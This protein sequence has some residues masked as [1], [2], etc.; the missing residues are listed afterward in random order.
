MDEEIVNIQVAV[1]NG[2]VE[3]LKQL[4]ATRS[5]VKNELFQAYAELKHR[6]IPL[7]NKMVH[8]VEYE[9]VK[10]SYQ[11]AYQDNDSATSAKGA[12]GE[13]AER[14]ALMVECIDLILN[15]HKPG[16]Y[17]DI[18]E[19][20][21]LRLRQIYAH[22]FF[23]KTHLRKLPLLQLQ[24][25]LAVFL[26]LVT[27]KP[28]NGFDIYAFTIDKER[29]IHFL[30]LTRNELVAESKPPLSLECYVQYVLFLLNPHYGT[31]RIPKRIRSY[32]RIGV[33]KMSADLVADIQPGVYFEAFPVP[34]QQTLKTHYEKTLDW[35]HRR[36]LR[37]T[38]KE[39][40]DTYFIMKQ[41]YSIRKVLSY[42]DGIREGPCNDPPHM[43]PPVPS[44]TRIRAIK[45]T[46]QV[47]GEMIKSTRE[48]PNITAKLNRILQLI[49]S[50]AL[51]ERTKDLRQFFSHGYSLAKWEM[52]EDA[53]SEQLA[54]VFQN[55]ETNLREVRRWFVYTQTQQNLLIYRRYLAHLK[56]FTSVV[57]LRSYISFVGTEFKASLI[58]TYLPEQL[59]EAK[60]LI[61]YMLN[62]ASPRESL[63]ADVRQDLEYILAEL[64]LRIDVIRVE[65][66]TL[67]RTIDEFFFLESYIRQPTSEL[68][69]VRQIVDWI[70]S[71]T[72]LSNRHKL[73]QKTDLLYARELLARLQMEETDDTRRYLWGN[74]WTR[75][76][77]ERLSGLDTL[78]GRTEQRFDVSLDATVRTMQALNLPLDGDEYV[79]FVN[80]RLA[81]SYYTNVFGLDNKY[82]VLKEI[83]KDRR[84]QVNSRDVLE[85]LKELRKTDERALQ[86]MFDGL[87]DSMEDI[88]NECD[89]TGDFRFSCQSDH[90]ALE[91]C[92]L[93]A[94]EILCNLALFR[95]NMV[96]LAMFVPV[97]TGRNLRNY[98]AHDFLAYDTLTGRDGGETVILNARYL[99]ENR[100]KLYNTASGRGPAAS[101][102]RSSVQRE[103]FRE[104][105]QRQ[106]E[107][108]MEQIDF[109][110]TIGNLRADSLEQRIQEL[111]GA[112]GDARL[113]LARRNT[114]DAEIVSIALDGNTSRFIAQLLEYE[115]NNSNFFHLL[116]K[117]SQDATL[118]E[119]LKT[120]IANPVDFCCHLALKYGLLDV[121]CSLY[122]RYNNAALRTMLGAEISSIFVRYS[123]EFI[124][125]L[126]E[127]FPSEWFQDLQDHI[128][129]TILHLMVLR[130]DPEMLL[131]ALRRY[132][133][134]LKAKNEIGD[135]PLLIACRYHQDA[136]VEMLLDHRA[137]A[138][139]EP[140]VVQTL[141]MRSSTALLERLPVDIGRIVAGQEDTLRTNPLRAAIEENQYDTFVTLH[142]VFRYR[143]HKGELLHLAARMNR[144]SFLRYILTTGQENPEEE[145]SVDSISKE[146]FFTPL[147]LACATGHYEA[148]ELL[149]RY[150]ADG[151]L[152]NVNHYTPW[153]CAVH[154]G[155][156]RI[157]SLLL[158]IQGLDVNAISRDKR[159]AL[160]IAI[161]TDQPPAK[162][163]FLLSTARVTVQPEHV[164]HACLFGKM[165][166]L[167]ML[168]ER[169]PQYLS[170]HDFLLRSPL[171]LAVVLNDNAM[172]QYLL[173]RGANR[174]TVNVLG[175]NCLHVA[176]LSNLITIC[177]TLLDAQMNYEAVDNFHRTPLVV[178]LENEHLTIADLLLQRGA[179]LKS[180]HDFRFKHHRN[181]TLLHKFTIEQRPRMVE[182]LVKKLHFPTD[183]LDDDGKT[184]EMYMGK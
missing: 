41:H 100:P 79:Q 44:P 101:K 141:A 96:D 35:D 91:Y 152:R 14:L 154:S 183:L 32:I 27:G 174:D 159:S 55:I 108:T 75:L 2:N 175:M 23:V 173:E 166:I 19:L 63:G 85:K 177:K 25:C 93:E 54:M 160:S 171:M 115:E 18:D 94:T 13:V 184:A 145:I 110:D 28:T 20:L 129:N 113:L 11:N 10:V 124:S 62:T 118:I 106:T 90:L 144:V 7:S 81:K 77:K 88:L 143:L 68:G 87:L 5:C 182:Y 158:S 42:I 40:I 78:L 15:E 111:E 61:Q 172:A 46:L 72:E 170:A 67:G 122:E 53:N 162:I 37:K 135:V 98:L 52:E 163:N 155:N 83:V 116:I 139:I 38:F 43:H 134:L 59:T 103:H 157:I 109:F 142:R 22:V 179:S 24:F 146:Y 99:V 151:L 4:L 45:R 138:W 51:T 71:R 132:Q 114:L 58:E 136:I 92:L 112:G 84:A 120:I 39:L 123:T 130:G 21:V 117:Y 29:I 128:G 180:A 107:W 156:R 26:K 57:K 131:F 140:K 89:R 1:V 9:L 168:I 119:K 95:D 47:I 121:L 127:L 133:V 6:N 97:I 56:Q 76:A 178:A 165:D 30:K 3:Q 102:I 74:I 150:G 148:A 36:R 126:I 181:A 12:P 16:S 33:K 86:Q 65:N 17:N 104:I 8:F 70:L 80:R 49:T 105:F 137:D 161:D 153:H 82:R 73:V 125:G 31:H 147:M 149:L 167:K 169:E 66:D 60:M 50:E 176:A 34:L 69:R 48:S 164:L 64:Q